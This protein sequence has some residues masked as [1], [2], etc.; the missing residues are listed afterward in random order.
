MGIFDKIAEIGK[1]VVNKVKDWL[2]SFG[3]EKPTLAVGTSVEAIKELSN[4]NKIQKEAAQLFN[5]PVKEERNKKLAEAKEKV[6]AAVKTATKKIKEAGEFVGKRLKEGALPV[7]ITPEVQKKVS[8][9]IS[10][11]PGWSWIENEPIGKKIVKGAL[12]IS[13]MRGIS[14]ALLHYDP[15]EER[16]IRPEE[17]SGWDLFDAYTLPV[18]VPFKPVKIGKYGTLITRGIEPEKIPKLLPKIENWLFKEGGLQK[19]I[20]EMVKIGKEGYATALS[21][22]PKENVVKAFL[23]TPEAF[24]LLPD[25]H[26]A[27]LVKTLYEFAPVNKFIKEI[28]KIKGPEAGA[29]ALK[30]A[31]I[32]FGNGIPKISYA[33]LQRDAIVPTLEGAK[34]GKFVK[35]DG[36]TLQAMAKYWGEEVAKYFI[37]KPKRLIEIDPS[38]WEYIV[39]GFEAT[40]EGKELLKVLRKEWVKEVT[41]VVKPAKTLFK[42]G[43]ISALSTV[44]AMYIAFQHV[45]MMTGFRKSGIFPKD[46]ADKWNDIWFNIAKPALDTFKSY[47]YL[48]CEEIDVNAFKR[49]LERC[50]EASD[51]LADMVAWF[52]AHPLSDDMVSAIKVYF[53]KLLGI[54]MERINEETALVLENIWKAYDEDV[55]AILNIV[56][57]KCP[58]LFGITSGL[59]PEEPTY[60]SEFDEEYAKKFGD[61]IVEAYVDNNPIKATVWL[62]GELQTFEEDVVSGNK[63]PMRISYV[64]PGKHTI[65]VWA[66]GFLPKEET[67]EI[68]AGEEVLFKFNL[69]REPPEEEEPEDL[70]KGRILIRSD[71]PG[72]KIYLNGEYQWAE[73][74]H[75][76]SLKP[77]K[78]VLDLELYGYV[79]EP[80]DF[81]IKAGDD[82]EPEPFK[83]TPIEELLP[84]EEVKKPTAW[85]YDII[86]Y[87]EGA[88]ISVDD[89]FTGKYTP[90]Y[91]L[92]EPEAT[93]KI[94]LTK[95][96]YEPFEVEITTEPFP[97]EV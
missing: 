42:Y 4:I 79:F 32:E 30:D 48:K 41:K 12:S 44:G 54:R 46:L 94:T 22:M 80:Y 66:D 68:K 69:E 9:A 90:D 50:K 20:D 96:G 17:V 73:T 93:Y 91:V 55:V 88:K 58:K 95:P 16:E 1:K 64:E 14:R 3:V 89:S 19:F 25:E 26:L 76:F 57:S 39:R 47:R 45:D 36:P 53:Q 84:P 8:E 2:D 21:K 31:I 6:V 83:L 10:K 62:D 97:E 86:S 56:K 24:H 7:K 33:L 49:A 34:L 82:L 70:V 13:G 78:Y 5:E 28:T 63:T 37:K 11:L 52:K 59:E 18:M 23:H 61:I 35:A 60:K 75:L 71:P 43:T 81:E 67:K 85:R 27:P 51:K 15:V 77:G 65:K 92:L 72:A 74:P 29:K 40:P 38:A 87:P